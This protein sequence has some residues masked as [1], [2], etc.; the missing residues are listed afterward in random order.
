MRDES[1]QRVELRSLSRRSMYQIFAPLDTEERLPR[2]LLLDGQESGWFGGPV[3]DFLGAGLPTRRYRLI[4]KRHI[5][6]F[7][8][9][10]A[11]MAALALVIWAGGNLL[12]ALAAFAMLLALFW[13]ITSPAD[14]AP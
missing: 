12:A 10:P 11:L 3:R 9:G 7:L 1:R 4:G 13:L 6:G 8:W 5:A 2:E 14:Q